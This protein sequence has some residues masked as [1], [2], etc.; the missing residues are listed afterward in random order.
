MINQVKKTQDSLFGWGTTIVIAIIMITI[1]AGILFC[2][3]AS[4]LCLPSFKAETDEICVITLIK[5]EK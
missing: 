5:E 3:P 1:T 2:C 4:S